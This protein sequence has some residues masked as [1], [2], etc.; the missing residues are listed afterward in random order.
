MK[1]SLKVKNSAIH[2]KGLFASKS[3][4]KGTF[5]GNCKTEPTAEP[6]LYTLWL[7]DDNQV[8][9]TCKFKYINHSKK[10]NVAY[11]EDLTVT[12]LKN[13]KKGDEL[14]HDYGDEWQ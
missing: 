13:I 4:E 12:A 6:G 2:G 3:I 9:V 7:S 10:P 5:L 8:D 1:A 11:H 14:T